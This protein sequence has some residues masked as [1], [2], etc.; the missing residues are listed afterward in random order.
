[1]LFFSLPS[2][3]GSAMSSSHTHIYGGSA[4]F[5]GCPSH[6][7]NETLIFWLP[8]N[9]TD[10]H[11]ACSTSLRGLTSLTRRLQRGKISSPQVYSAF[12]SGGMSTAAASVHTTNGLDSYIQ[13][14]LVK[15]SL[16][17]Y[18][19]SGIPGMGPVAELL[20]LHY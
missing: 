5:I 9:P 20:A 15:A 13:H 18:S 1:M 2:P 7:R 17:G 3:L 14:S 12:L 19:V 11:G 6:L 4:R 10:E 8:N 16:C